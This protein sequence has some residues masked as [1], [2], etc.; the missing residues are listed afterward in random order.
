LRDAL[1]SLILERGYE[2]ITVGD[3]TDRADLN[4]GT[5]YLHYRDKQDLLLRSSDEVYK[6]LL[7]QFEPLNREHLSLN[8]PE[9]HLALVFEHAAAHADFYRVM[10]G[11]HGVP[12]FVNRL[13]QIVAEASRSRL[14]GLRA[15]NP[16][17]RSV[18]PELVAGFTS[19]ALLGALAWW[20]ESG[21][22]TPI[23]QVAQTTLELTV[24]GVYGTLGIT[25]D[26]KKD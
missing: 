13:R 11:D 18:S 6:D 1:I 9:R 12:A 26:E 21:M 17:S 10:L 5:L 25:V 16:A 7:T 22:A 24:R 3:I 2:A 4:R 20:L 23:D 15:L 8:V 19:G 14:D